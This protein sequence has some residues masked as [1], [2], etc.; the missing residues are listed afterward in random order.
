M[1]LSQIVP[2]ISLA[3]FTFFDGW[4]VGV[5]DGGSACAMLEEV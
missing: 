4:E 3:S 1:I 2:L 5:S